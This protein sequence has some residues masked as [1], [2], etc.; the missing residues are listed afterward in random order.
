MDTKLERLRYRGPEID[1]LGVRVER[2][3]VKPEDQMSMGQ[4]LSHLMHSA[5]GR[6]C[7]PGIYTGLRVD[8]VLWM[9]DTVAE[10][11]D[12][13][14][15]VAMADLFKD[16]TGLVNGLG[17]GCVVGAML[18]SLEHVDVVERDERIIDTV[19]EWYRDTYGDRVT[20][21]HGDALA[22]HW[23]KGCYW[24]VVWHDIWPKLSPENLPEMATLHRRFARRSAWQ[25][26]WGH[27]FCKWMRD[28]ENGRV[29]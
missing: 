29:S 21:I 6:G 25:G 3:E 12:H 18:D 15:P 7:P 2:F 27:E 28:V 24:S 1:D 9:S 8:D 5:V 4:F 22:Y 11:K 16:G 26:S 19:G 20:I 14:E 17:L 10:R 23:P 13:L